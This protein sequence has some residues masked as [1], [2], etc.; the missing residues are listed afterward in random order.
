MLYIIYNITPSSPGRR[1]KPPRKES[2]FF[3]ISDFGLALAD[4]LA[5]LDL[6]LDE[7]RSHFFALFF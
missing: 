2:K 5:L 1:L 3:Q 6:D 7:Y 4:L